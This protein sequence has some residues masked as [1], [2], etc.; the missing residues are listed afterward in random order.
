M[1]WLRSGFVALALLS[2]LATAQPARAQCFWDGVA[3]VCW[4]HPLFPEL[5]L[6]PDANPYWRW[7]Q[8]WGGPNWRFYGWQP[9]EP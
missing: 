1:T 2:V 9:M 8:N 7:T 4:T 6:V 5:S 3:W